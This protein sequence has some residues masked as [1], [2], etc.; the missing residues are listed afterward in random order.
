MPDV[1]QYNSFRYGVC[2]YNEAVAFP[3]PSV[4]YLEGRFGMRVA[5]FEPGTGVCKEI[6][7]SSQEEMWVESCEFEFTEQG[8]GAFSFYVNERP[9]AGRDPRRGDRVEISLMQ[10]TRPWFSGRIE[11]TPTLNTETKKLRYK[12]NGYAKTFGEIVVDETYADQLVSAAVL[13]LVETYLGTGEVVFYTDRLSTVPVMI[14]SVRFDRIKLKEALKRLGELAHDWVY[15][16]DEERQFFFS[17]RMGR[18]LDRNRNKASHWVGYTAEAFQLKEKTD[19]IS[20]KLHVKI[21][22]IADNSNFADFT[23]EDLDSVAFFGER[24]KVVSAPDLKDGDEAETWAGYQLEDLAW[25]EITAKAGGLDLRQF[26]QSKDDL[27]R[28]EGF[29]RVGMARAGLVSP[30]YEPLNGYYRWQDIGFT[31]LYGVNWLRTRF[32]AR[33]GG[34]LGRVEV[35]LQRFGA[36]GTL[37]LNIYDQDTVGDLD[38][39]GDGD[40]FGDGDDWGGAG[41]V[42]PICTQDIDGSTVADYCTWCVIDL[43]DPVIVRKDREYTIELC[44]VAGQK[45]D[46]DGWGD[47]DAWG[48]GDEWGGDAN[49][50]FRVFYS[51]YDATYSHKYF[52]SADAGGNWTEDTAKGLFSRVYLVHEDEFILPIKKVTYKATP[53]GGLTADLDLGSIEMPLEREVL[54][55]LRSIKAEEYL[56]QSN[57]GD[58]S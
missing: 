47:G 57:V 55:L 23:V 54:E 31:E 6:H 25:P 13:D 5:V 38:A 52:S 21:G 45:A 56:Q 39:F 16:V 8:C 34:T 43:D 50:Y 44:A 28:A 4:A 17:P 46:G 27:L 33:D 49:N 58:L 1:S 20:N 40:Y 26:V 3:T 10:S 51:T 19:K 53:E 36:P 9:G 48:E 7:D 15:G 42:A 32:T 2:R 14:E 35:M 18:P 12:G 30:Y 41:G 22:A 11:E 24:E 29:F 37:R